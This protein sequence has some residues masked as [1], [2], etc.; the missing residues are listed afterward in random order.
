MAEAHVE[1]L[2]FRQH[3][4]DTW[5][6]Q[7]GRHTNWPVVYTLND[8]TEVYVGETLNAVG[9]LRQHLANPEKQHL[10][11]LR[12]VVDETFN[13]SVCLDLESY[14]I[15]LFA[16]DGK[17]KVLNRNDGITNSD[18]YGR[19]E[20]R[21]RFAEIFEL[22]R[23][24]QLFAQSIEQI[25]NSDLFKL[26]PFK[27]LNHDQEAA[28][29]DILN[30]FFEDLST[31]AEN[32]AV[33]QG[34]PGTGK[35]IVAIYLIKLLVDIAST[36]PSDDA[37]VDSVFSDFFVEDNREALKS[38]SIGLVVPQQSLRKSIKNVFKRTP[39]LDPSMVLTP[40]EVA[41]SPRRFDLLVVDETHR[42]TQYGAQS[43]GTLTAD[44]RTISQRLAKP[45]ERWEDLTQL[46]W[47]I[48]S[49]KQ[50]VLMLDKAQSVRPI[51]LP[52][53]VV[54]RLHAY[55]QATNRGYTLRSQMR[56]QGG[57]DYIEFVSQL[58][59]D[60]PPD[61]A[62]S[63][64]DYQFK[65][66]Y[67]LAEMHQVIRERNRE[68]GLARL[69]AGYGWEWRSKDDPLGY[70]IEL[71]GLKLAWNRTATDWINSPTSIDEVGSIHTVQGYDLN[72]AGVI[73]GPELRWNTRS[74]RLELDRAHYFDKKGKARNGLLGIDYS[75]DEV[76]AY[77]R[78]I[79]RVLLTRGMRGTYVY[80]CDPALRG[81]MSPYIGG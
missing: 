20:Y 29:V 25:Q 76:L 65:F 52:P 50:Q 24:D 47:I 72:Y 4:I 15:A 22:L 8:S 1:R 56:V 69:V 81:R 18:Y 64:P 19:E 78:N 41:K 66:F 45:G 16:G 10:T 35:T 31:G 67:N 42:L 13:K 32:T 61:P 79:Y 43:M 51:D 46:D 40:Y 53:R 55:A 9:R 27:A 80:I 70:D 57:A 75:D 36:E 59:S 71:D 26:S 44:F 14:L 37:G 39:G 33:I 74:Q 63:F 17:L 68:H 21:K 28:I 38:F 54:D 34:G 12:V 23:R 5:T 7:H 77:V 49:S 48:R 3:A 62:P 58:L 73:I 6:D 30:G 11:S 2:P 60:N